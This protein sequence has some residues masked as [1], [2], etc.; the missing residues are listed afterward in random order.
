MLC[1][2]P[3]I[4]VDLWEIDKMYKTEGVVASFIRNI[5]N[6]GYKK[7]K[8]YS[9]EECQRI[10]SEVP[11]Q[12][13]DKSKVSAQNIIVIMNEAYADL[14]VIGETEF[15]ENYMPFLNSLTENVVKGNLYVPVFG[16]QTCNTEFE[17]LTGI[18]CLDNASVPYQSM[19]NKDIECLVS[20]LKENS[21][22]SMAF[23]PYYAE[24]WNRS[25]VYSYMGFEKFI[26]I[27]ELDL[28]EDDMLRCFVS[29]EYNYRYIIEQYEN[30]TTNK[31]FIFNVTMQ[32]HG[33]YQ[34]EF[35]NFENT[36]DLTQYGDF[37]QT[38]RYLS[39]IRESDRAIEE[40]INYFSEIEEP[41]L[42]CIFG[43]H[44]PAIETEFYEY[45][46]GKKIEKLSKKEQSKRYITPI[47]IWTNYDIEEQN[48]DRVSANFLGSLILKYANVSMSP[49]E[50]FLYQ[51]YQEFPVVSCNGVW[52]ANGKYYECDIMDEVELLHQYQLLQYN[53]LNK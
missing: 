13:A 31:E 18:A 14:S 46:Y 38:E 33:G 43:D 26:A 23:H 39:L 16:G 6:M 7:P 19:I 30:K 17:V 48:I 9:D 51:L 36:V 12:I 32:N 25:K 20:T 47:T 52:S 40:L 35:D 10:L 41:T 1:I 44:Q 22:D 45:L 50:S 5:E 3:S 28:D 24:N 29:D 21:Y 37:P 34:G 42:I 15:G 2:Y 4:H 8:G 53:R 11:L 49:Y 27:D